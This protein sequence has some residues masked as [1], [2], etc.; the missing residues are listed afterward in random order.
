M[1]KEIKELNFP[2]IGGKQ[3]A[4]LTQATVVLQDMAEKTITTQV[5]IDGEITPD[6]TYDWEVEFQGEKYIMPLRQPQGVKENTSLDSTIDLTFHH[7]AIYQL[8][9]W[10]FFTLADVAAGTA[11]PDKY[12][13]SVSLNLKDFCDLLSKIL[14]YYYGDKITL[15][16]NDPGKNPGGWR[17]SAEPTT[18]EISHTLIWDVLKN[19]YTLY[20]VRWSIEPNGDSDHYVIRVGYPAKSIDHIFQYGFDGG[21]LKVERQVQDENIRNMLI[22]RGGEKNLPYR[23]FKRHDEEN[24][25]FSP[26]P[27]WIPELANIPF[28]ELHG[29]TYRSYIQGWKAAHAQEY[30]S[31]ATRKEAYKEKY[32]HDYPDGEPWE[33]TVPEA[34]GAYAPWAWMRGY[35]DD[36]FNPVDF[37]ADGFDESQNGYGVIKD[38]SIAEYG[39]I[40][41]GLDNNEEIYPTIQGVQGNGIGRVDEAVWVE[42]VQ[43]DD[44][45]SEAVNTLVGSIGVSR[46]SSSQEIGPGGRAVLEVVSDWFDVPAGANRLDVGEIAISCSKYTL[47]HA[48][49][50]PMRPDWVL[51]PCPNDG[52]V[53]ESE[54]VRVYDADGVE[55]SV[56]GLTEGRYYF[57]STIGIYNTNST[58]FV[59][60]T[61]ENARVVSANEDSYAGWNSIFRVLVKNIWDTRQGYDLDGKV[62]PG[63]ET[64]EQYAERVWRPILDDRVGNEA[65][66]VFADGALSVSEDYE[67]TI[68]SF[69]KYRKQLCSFTDKQGV[70][71]KW[72][73]EWELTLAKSDADMESLGM[74]VPNTKR[75]GVAGDHFFFIGIDMPHMYVVKAEERLD[76]WKKD[77]LAKVMAIKPTWV[78]GLDKVRIHNYG[79]A[80]ALVDELCVG[81]SFRL[82]DKRFITTTDEKGEPVPS[83]AETL[84]LQSVT[85]TYNE[86]TDKEANLLPDVEV[87]LSDTPL[88]STGTGSTLSGEVSALQRQIGSLGNIEQLVR[89]IGDKLWLRKDGFRDISMSATEF[90]AMVSSHGFRSGM[91]EGS[92]WGVLKDESG[93]TIF[94]A[95]ILRAR[96]GIEA[97]TFVINQISVQGGKVVRSAAV[98]ECTRVIEEG[99]VYVCYFDQRGGSV[100]NLFA[101]GDVALSEVMDPDNVRLK[102]YKRRVMGVGTDYIKLTKGYAAVTLA[103]GTKDTGVNGDGVPMAG[104][105]I[106]H[107]GSYTNPKRRFVMVIDVIGGGYERCIQA[108]DSV[109]TDGEE[110]YFAGRQMGMYGDGPRWFVGDQKKKIEYKNGEFHL[111][112]VTL[113]VDSK[114]GDT[115]I[116]DL[117][118]VVYTIEPTASMIN[119]PMYA[120]AEDIMLGCVVYRSKGSEARVTT[121]ECMLWCTQLPDG[122]PVVLSRENGASEMVT[123]GEDT[124]EVLF[125]LR[126]DSMVVA[127]AR[128]PVVVNFTGLAVGGTNLIL[129]SGEPRLGVTG[130]AGA[131]YELS[132]TLESGVDYVFN[133][134]SHP[135][136]NPTYSSWRLYTVDDSGGII[137]LLGTTTSNGYTKELR[138]KYSPADALKAVKR[139]MVRTARP[140]SEAGIQ[141]VKLER[142]TISTDWSPSPYD[143]MDKSADYLKAAMKESTTVNNG[144]VLTSNI[145]MG[146]TD[147][148]G[149]WKNTS[150]MNGVVLED[151][152]DRSIMMWAGGKQVD[153]ASNPDEGAAMAVR[154]D[155]SGYFSHNTVRFDENSFELGDN[156]KIANNALSM[157]KDKGGFPVLELRADDIPYGLLSS[158]VSRTISG[159]FS[160]KGTVIHYSPT[161]GSYYVDPVLSAELYLLPNVDIG[162]VLSGSIT[163]TFKQ[164]NSSTANK[165]TPTYNVAEVQIVT[166]GGSVLY[167]KASSGR[168]WSK[169][170]IDNGATIVFSKTLNINWTNDTTNSSNLA[171]K[172]SAGPTAERTWDPVLLQE[173]DFRVAINLDVDGSKTRVT[174]LG[175]NGIAALWNESRLIATDEGVAIGYGDKYIRISSDGIKIC[176]DGKTEVDL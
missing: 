59:T 12:I 104:D 174:M 119:R 91:V 35:T 107:Y 151:I 53:K 28:T 20:A 127:E 1:I 36:K 63:G 81:S 118:T 74:Y 22:G 133:L 125:E 46:A 103:D 106:A 58:R 45:E 16:F 147:I 55:H 4:T 169:T 109:N 141:K 13:A 130:S 140:T 70:Q 39:E 32:S 166:T 8:N 40:M 18:V 85:Y 82:A 136:D 67:F 30:K 10:F 157:S 80:N 108:L 61:Y 172:I 129:N 112:G 122:D 19:L 83:S 139:L 62:I 117:S 167:S 77:E 88:S 126:K 162:A 161:S 11:V 132:T 101:V 76:N 79:E 150:G 14:N 124:T 87:V 105:V 27:D 90:A 114:V 99:D 69:P 110:Y 144:L 113:S 24:K 5:R 56:S 111:D 71:R 49:G 116:G 7:W 159:V 145:Q 38:S 21:L 164:P 26:D 75:Q 96:K 149:V 17:Y 92:G 6:F 73:S 160:K 102:Y 57:K 33:V 31:Y 86:P 51:V 170:V 15:D 165:T 134:W 142:G 64:E 128:V 60:L 131:I 155:G 25:T 66:V 97:N 54:S 52:V 47:T 146:Y 153:A 42:Q 3:Y 156:I 138:F 135:D 176:R 34:A 100:K 29:A 98:M 2:K 23:Y 163:I 94:E 158:Q 173:L 137:K 143:A 44:V 121:N 43:S 115:M 48:L 175:A 171:L 65:K 168:L 72:Y 41:G 84:Y 123:I 50:M 95:D 89:A 93:N 148:D 154:M 78:V 68:A 152:G 37:V 120:S 9:R